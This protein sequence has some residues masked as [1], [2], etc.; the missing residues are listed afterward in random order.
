MKKIIL[1]FIFIFLWIGL[2]LAAYNNFE[3]SW[4]NW[5]ANVNN[6]NPAND[7]WTLTWRLDVEDSF[8]DEYLTNWKRWEITWLII[9]DLFWEFNTNIV[10]KKSDNNDNCDLVIDWWEE[11]YFTWATIHS[12]EWWDLTIDDSSSYFC[13]NK[14]ISLNLSSD[15][16][17]NKL[18]WDGE[19]LLWD[20]SDFDKQEI[21]ITGIASLDNKDVN[22]DSIWEDNIAKVYVDVSSKALVKS[23]IYKNIHTLTLNMDPSTNLNLT[24]LNWGIKYYDYKWETKT[25]SFDSIDYKNEWEILQIWND[26]IWK[27]DIEWKNT[28]IVENWN[29]Y[30]NSNLDNGD[31][32]TDL[33]V[34]VA[35]RDKQTGNGWNIYI[36]PNVTNIDA[37]L[38]ADASLISMDD[39]DYSIQFLPDNSN[40]LRKQLLIYGSVLS[41]NSVWSDNI[42][43]WADYYED[44]SYPWNTMDFSIYDL[45]NLRTF[46]LNYGSWST[47]S[48]ETKLAPINWS[49]DYKL[50][51][52]AWR[53]N[54][55]NSED[56]QD[57]LRWSD[58]NNS[59]I[60]EYNS[61]VQ[62]IAPYILQK[63]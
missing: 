60:V 30:I 4:D 40:N 26:P 41:S 23:N 47:C 39:I 57:W 5:D 44:I 53:K 49:G 59:V 1:S 42:P 46:N 61:N 6:S 13:Q 36:D 22:V 38:I 8:S 34:L 45:A 58:K 16:L 35:T 62:F 18:V 43:Y 48:D 63:N 19:Q 54:C 20:F 32:K 31:D 15:T 52:W 2:V 3:I 56:V 27:I 24:S 50:N 10:Y 51:A 9:S 12:D 29:I 28:V 33:L 25:L 55:Y 17:W 21:A 7:V 37:V 14:Y 11:Y